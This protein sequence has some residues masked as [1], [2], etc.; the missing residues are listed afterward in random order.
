MRILFLG[1]IV[2]EPGRKSVIKFLPIIQKEHAI[3]FTIVNGENSAG[4][5]GITPNIANDLFKAGADVITTGDHVWDQRELADHLSKENRILRPINYPDG[6]P[7]SGLIIIDTP[8]QA[9]SG[10]SVP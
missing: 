3:D 7:G 8:L 5:R 4:G 10:V 1:D 2:G 6:V 9:A